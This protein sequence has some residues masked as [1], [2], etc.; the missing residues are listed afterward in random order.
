VLTSAFTLSVTVTNWMAG[1]L[2]TFSRQR[3]GRALQLSANALCLVVVLWGVQ[4]Q[5][6][7]TADFFIGYSN[8]KRFILRPE[9]G[10]PLAVGRVF[11]A[12]SMVMPELR[13]TVD[14][15]WG[16]TL[17]VQHSG[18]ASGGR[19]AVLALACWGALLILG[20]VGLRAAPRPVVVLL[21]GMAI[22]Q[23]GLHVVF[24]EETFLYTLHFV[25]LLV[26]LA[27][28]GSETRARGAVL[29]LAG[30]FVVA[31]AINNVRHLSTALAF[32]ADRSPAIVRPLTPPPCSPTSA[33]PFS[34]SSGSR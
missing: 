29:A 14:P 23:F 11:L 10:G 26:I 31:A 1:L 13:S 30:L 34:P 19:L 22:A 15:K 5:V 6:F 17:T 9:S 4:R 2:V 12:H 21:I 3:V 16:S 24:G 33:T 32:V 25:P 28:W 18:V 20:L 8:Y 27:S 7:P